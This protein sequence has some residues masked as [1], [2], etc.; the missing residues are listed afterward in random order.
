MSHYARP[1]A[2]A[3]RRIGTKQVEQLLPRT[4]AATVACVPRTSCAQ[5]QNQTRQKRKS[6]RVC[7]THLLGQFEVLL[8]RVL[9]LRCDG[10]Q[11]RRRRCV[12]WLRVSSIHAMCTQPLH[13]VSGGPISQT[14]NTCRSPCRR[15]KTMCKTGMTSHAKRQSSGLRK[16]NLPLPAGARHDTTT[17]RQPPPPVLPPR[18][19]HT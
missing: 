14:D 6:R 1:L 4:D 11:W 17:Q 2:D 16:L 8:L 13:S 3:L 15:P 10:R 9:H 19:A 5:K 18:S 12:R 7:A